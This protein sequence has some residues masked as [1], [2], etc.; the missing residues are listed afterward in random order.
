LADI[1]V[2]FY[3]V[4]KKS[5]EYMIGKNTVFLTFLFLL[6]F[7][8]YAQRS[9]ADSLSQALHL[10]GLPSEKISLLN[11]LAGYYSDDN[12]SR[13]K[14]YAD[15]AFFI[16]E[17]IHDERGKA[18]A[19][20]YLAQVAIHFR[21][22]EKAINLLT[23]S[24]N[25]FIKLKEDYW[26]A[27]VD[28]S[29]GIQFQR[30]HEYEKALEEF[31]NALSVF[32]TEKKD[33]EIAEALYAIGLN[34]FEQGN[35][36]KA[37]EYY[38][39]SLSIF[40]EMGDLLGMGL[41][42]TSMGEVFRIRQNFTES[43][44]YLSLAAAVNQK[45]DKPRILLPTYIH[46]GRLFIDMA[47]YDSAQYYLG[48]AE[49]LSNQT[50]SSKLLP[51]IKIAAGALNMKT[52]DYPES[53]NH[54]TQGYQL[55]VQLG[56]MTAMRD[57][58]KGLSEINAFLNDYHQAYTYHLIYKQISDSI[59]SIRNT[60]KITQMEMFNL[61][62]QQLKS[63]MVNQQ[64]A[65]MD[66][67]VMTLIVVIVLIG[68][69]FL[70]GR[71]KIK[72][73][74]DHSM[75]QILQLEHLKLRDQVDHKNRMLATNVLYMVRKNEL[76]H[77]ISDKL[78]W[79]MN[80]MKEDNKEKIREVL[81]NLRSNIDKNIWNVFEERFSDVHQN[82]FVTL[83]N[84]FPSLTGKERKLCALL[85]LN[86]TTKEIA[87]ITHQNINAV[88]VARTRLRKKLNLSN[89]DVQLSSFLGSL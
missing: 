9:D 12:P 17:S 27:K 49:V 68:V 69:V 2:C 38:A 60:E 55:S 53:L 83:Q 37:F 1:F 25:E 78:A 59:S 61:Y 15:Q 58:S 44:H 29:L 14:H 81:L 48:L 84:R 88:E 30:K 4:E 43:L 74:Y 36:E 85:R 21:E 20:F 62:D 65:R 51:Q 5:K 80:N 24:R 16:A 76:I 42:Y 31:Y 73:K 77:Y 52:E 86:L 34:F 47:E 45:Q 57:A 26:S 32:R 8:L 72:T 63:D 28:V 89:T 82:F 19:Q 79:F 75:A 23:L 22:W 18:I 41:L 13:S 66:F 70:Y 64:K 54:Y 40:R 46:L 39:S 10:T 11:Q 6:Q 56:N 87:A 33:R 50:G 35:S 71:L 7:V 67:M 3:Q